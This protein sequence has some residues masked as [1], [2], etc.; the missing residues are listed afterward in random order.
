MINWERIAELREEIGE[1]DFSEV[2]S[3]FLS[4]IDE[5]ILRLKSNPTPES[6]EQDLHFLRSSALNLGF[7]TF[8]GLCLEGEQVAADGNAAAVRLAPIFRSY[9]RSRAAFEAG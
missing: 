3:M 1:E 6:F 9:E 7:A 2:A 5:V 4:E 8:G